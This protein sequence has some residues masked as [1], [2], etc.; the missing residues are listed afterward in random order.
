MIRVNLFCFL[1]FCLYN[2]VVGLLFLKFMVILI[3]YVVLILIRGFRIEV[4][5]KK[6]FF[7]F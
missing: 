6:V 3:F 4:G 2:E 1:V 5:R 7:C